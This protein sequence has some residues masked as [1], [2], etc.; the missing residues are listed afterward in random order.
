MGEERGWV[1]QVEYLPKE[2]RGRA[3]RTVNWA[4]GGG[5]AVETHSVSSD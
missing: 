2:R 4:V 5:V 3:S 1:G